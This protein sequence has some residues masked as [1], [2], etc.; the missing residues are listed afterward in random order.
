MAFELSRPHL[1]EVRRI[2]LWMILAAGFVLA[3]TVAHAAIRP[4]R[5]SCEPASTSRTSVTLLITA[6]NG[7]SFEVM[8]REGQV[9]TYRDDSTGRYLGLSPRIVDAAGGDLDL[10]VYALAEERTRDGG[11]VVTER[12]GSVRTKAGHFSYLP[13]EEFLRIDV[14]HIVPAATDSIGAGSSIE[15]EGPGET[16]LPAP[17]AGPCCVT[18]DILK[19]CGCSVN[20]SCGSCSGDC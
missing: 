13:L 15:P 8:I 12:L 3:D 2:I 19:V 6:K 14:T 9:A 10:G 17:G 7:Q 1:V 16:L 18:C 20:G 11:L 4:D 5:P